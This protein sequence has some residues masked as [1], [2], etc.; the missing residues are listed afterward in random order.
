MDK[1]W[2]RPLSCPP[3]KGKKFKWIKLLSFF[4]KKDRY[5]AFC[6]LKIHQ[7]WFQ[8]KQ[9]PR[10]RNT[11]TPTQAQ[12]FARATERNK[13]CY[14]PSK[15]KIRFGTPQSYWASKINATINLNFIIKNFPG[16]QIPRTPAARYCPLAYLLPITNNNPVPRKKNF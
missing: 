7:F 5:T 6:V 1:G 12:L 2:G 15:K 13:K 16:G 10:W 4:R 14:C 9:F 3:G 8:I 11:R